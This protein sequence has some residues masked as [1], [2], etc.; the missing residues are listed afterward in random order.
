VSVVGRMVTVAIDGGVVA[1]GLSMAVVNERRVVGRRFG[2]AVV[3]VD[4]LAVHAQVTAGG[5][6]DVGA[7]SRLFANVSTDCRV[8]VAVA[9]VVFFDMRR[10]WC[11][12]S[13][14]TRPYSW[15]SQPGI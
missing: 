5:V 9:R 14:S 7:E 6:S 2:V 11:R 8:S 12:L 1:I 15:A 13:F 3:C 4:V 10:M